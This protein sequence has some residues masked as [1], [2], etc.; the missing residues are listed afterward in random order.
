MSG[1]EKEEGGFF[2]SD[3]LVVRLLNTKQQQQ[4]VKLS[5]RS[6]GQQEFHTV[7]ARQATQRDKKYICQ[8]LLLET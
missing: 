6:G 2:G 3:K 1:L 4:Y 8:V 5:F 7:L